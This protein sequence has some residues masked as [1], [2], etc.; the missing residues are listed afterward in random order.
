[1]TSAAV[2]PVAAHQVRR[3]DIIA[4]R[5]GHRPVVEVERYSRAGLVYLHVADGT[6]R[7]RWSEDVEV[8]S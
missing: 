7:A 4:T 8:I 3:Q 1:M 2:R 6:V 5:F